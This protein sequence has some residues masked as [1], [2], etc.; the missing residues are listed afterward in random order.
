MDFSSF[1]GRLVDREL[2]HWNILLCVDPVG[3][4]SRAGN[5]LLCPLQVRVGG[6]PYPTNPPSRTYGGLDHQPA[7]FTPSS[8]VLQWCCLCLML[9]FPL[10]SDLPVE[11][12]SS[13]TSYLEKK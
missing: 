7:L 4:R 1:R 12:L 8:L 13:R 11:P 3:Q 5:P 2:V 10:P 6:P 9:S